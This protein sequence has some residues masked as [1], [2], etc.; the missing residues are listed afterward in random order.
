M[1]IALLGYGIEG[2][3]AYEHLKGLHSDAEFIVY[4]QAVTPKNTLPEDVTF[5]GDVED[6]HGIDADIVVRTPAIR[7]D[8]VSTSGQVTTVTQLFF[9]ACPAPIIGVTGTKGK[10]T[11]ASL[12]AAILQ[13]GGQTVHLV[14]NIGLAALTELPN[15]RENDVVVY[16]LSSFQLWDLNISPHVAVVLMIEPDHLDV[17]ADMHE[18]TAAKAKIAQY[19]TV[20]DIVVYNM[21]NQL[22]RKIAERS[23]GHKVPFPAK[24]F[25]HVDKD[26]FYYGDTKLCSVAALQLP[27]EHNIDNACAAI[28]AAWQWVQKDEDIEAGLSSFT[29]LPHRLKLVREVGEVK[30]YDDSIATTPGAAIAALRA[31]AQPKVMILGGSS[32]GADFTELALEIVKSDM[33]QVIVMGDEADAISTALDAAGISSYCLMREATMRDVVSRAEGVAQPG[34]VVVLS[35]ACASFG[36]FK[37]YKDRGERFIATVEEL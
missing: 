6:F 14:G 25:A 12:A 21:G 15:I 16:E 26:F 17:H 33:R 11:T 18:Y 35:P 24:Q 3:S 9:D 1:K 27:G 13:A 29:G 28:A 22:S 2:E 23:A 20:D 30:Y 36:M 7:P 5:V 4:D 32:K 31:F 19:Q 34:D 10:G 8:A 37:S